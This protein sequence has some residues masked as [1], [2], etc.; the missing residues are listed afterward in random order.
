[1]LMAN[2]LQNYNLQFAQH[3]VDESNGRQDK[4]QLH[5]NHKFSK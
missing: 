5:L 1:M 4:L 2:L 3:F